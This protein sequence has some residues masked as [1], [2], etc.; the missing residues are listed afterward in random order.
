MVNGFQII[1]KLPIKVCRW[2]VLLKDSGQ[3]FARLGRP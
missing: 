1:G 3:E 2:Y